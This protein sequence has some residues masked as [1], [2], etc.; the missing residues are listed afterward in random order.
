MAH[1]IFQQK[2]E[3]F[4]FSDFEFEFVFMRHPCYFTKK[5]KGL[6]FLNSNSS[7]AHVIFK[8][9]RKNLNFLN[10]NWNSNSNISGTHDILEKKGKASM[11]GTSGGTLTCFKS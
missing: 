8:K 4:K 5:S 1:M 11:F 7:G 2:R 6:N 9:K 10:W 3:N